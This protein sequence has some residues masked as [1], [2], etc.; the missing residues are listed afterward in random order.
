VRNTDTG[1]QVAEV[2][3]S[4]PAGVGAGVRVSVVSSGICGSDLHLVSLGALPVTLGH[5]FGGRL[6]DG[7]PVSVLPRVTCGTCGPCLSGDPQQCVTALAGA[8]GISRHGGMADEAWVEAGTARVLPADLPLRNAC[9][10][11]PLA[12]ALHGVH[13]A[14]VGPGAPVLVI[15]GG[16]IGLCAVAAARSLGAEVDILARHPARTAAGERLGAG[17]SPGRDY[18]IV[19]DAAGTQGAVDEA[20]QRVRPG[21]T[22]GILSTFWEPVTLG[23]G[24]QIKEVTLVPAFMYGHHH[25][26]GPVHDADDTD[27]FDDAARLLA[28]LPDL[29]G[30][31]ITH[32]FPLD[33][34][35]EAFRV[36]AD[37]STGAIKVVLEP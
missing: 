30:A 33:E 19:L 3:D 27:E 29:P 21:G 32:R 28:G 13:R 26:P 12:V 14:G 23:M 35:A 31:V 34:A 37:R 1:I 11:E 4:P 5:E 22:I 6:D 20:V 24:F 25:G 9:L 36:A 10:V 16:T 17:T 2:D 7:T 15:G 18:E 8:Y